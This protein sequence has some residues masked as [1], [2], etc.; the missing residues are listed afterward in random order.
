VLF[1]PRSEVGGCG[2]EGRCVLGH[3]RLRTRWH[4]ADPAI[5]KSLGLFLPAFLAGSNDRNPD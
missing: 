2:E 4:P 1:E 5:L 3:A